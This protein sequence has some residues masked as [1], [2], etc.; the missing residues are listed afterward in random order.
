ML[1]RLQ[2]IVNEMTGSTEI[3]LT[4]K[5]KLQDERLG[6]SSFAMVQMICAIEDEFDVEIPNAQIAKF[7]T[8]GDVEKFLQKNVK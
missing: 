2:K 5:T 6:F 8:V 4:S 3:V 1:E 7:K